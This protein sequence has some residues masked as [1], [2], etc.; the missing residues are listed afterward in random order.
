VCSGTCQSIP[1]GIAI[2]PVVETDW[3]GGYCVH[4]DVTNTATTP[5]TTWT[6]T[7]NTNQSTI[8]TS[9]KG[10]F[11]GSSGSVTV[12]PALAATQ[13]IDPGETNGSIGFCANRNVSGSG[14]L[15]FVVSASASY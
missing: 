2:V 6:S 15:P 1:G 10:N 12:T 3:G 7:I 9:W 13:V 5:T 14:V 11:A 4:L 8:Y